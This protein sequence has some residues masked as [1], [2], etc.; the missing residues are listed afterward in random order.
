MK[1]L[2]QALK[3]RENGLILFSANG[4]HGMKEKGN[5]RLVGKEGDRRKRE[6]SSQNRFKLSGTL[7]RQ[8]RN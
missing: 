2:F 8:R 7:L 3:F 1:L 5:K 6:T 4:G